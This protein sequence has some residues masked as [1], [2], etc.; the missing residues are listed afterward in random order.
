MRN[1]FRLSS[2]ALAIVPLAALA[3]E[4]APPAPPDQPQSTE[5][6]LVQLAQILGTLHY[7]RVLC[8]PSDGTYWRDRMQD[9]LRLEKPSLAE[10][11]ELISQ[12][13]AGYQSAQQRFATCTP[14]AEGFAADTAKQGEALSETIANSINVGTTRG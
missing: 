9:M 7:V 2:F 13:N 14:E 10:R 8:E 12:F 11:N 1:F 6:R 3:Q 4:S 5:A